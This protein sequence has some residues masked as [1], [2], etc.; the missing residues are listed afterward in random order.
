MNDRARPSRRR[1]CGRRLAL[2]MLL[3]AAGA[4]AA[5]G[6]P[7][8]LQFLH[9][10]ATTPDPET[11]AGVRLSLL[12]GRSGSVRAL[13]LGLVAGATS[14]DVRG[15]Q[16]QTFYAGVGGELR[17]LGLSA[18]VHL[19]QQ[20]V[21]GLQL[22]GLAAWSG[23]RVGGVQ[24][25][26]AVAYADGGFGGVQLSGLMNASDGPGG[27]LQ[28]ASVAN[29]NV[30]DFRGVQIAGFVNHA[31]AELSGLQLGGF[32]NAESAMGVQVGLVNLGGEMNGFQ[33][34]AINRA[35][36]LDG[37]PVG[38]INTTPGSPRGWIFYGSTLS[39]GNLSYHT[40]VNRWTSQLSLGYGDNHGSQDEA[41]TL[42]WHYGYRV[43]GDARWWLG[44][45]LGFVHIMP[46]ASD[47]PEV[48]D[49]LHWALQPR[50][51]G[52]LALGRH[53]G[54]WAAAGASFIQSSYDSGA[55]SETELLL[56][57]GVVLR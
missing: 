48:N 14:G 9:P 3:L 30:G 55:E 4:V 51:N 56:A 50:L 42:A 2:T 35:R 17:G 31:N 13:D 33:I 10:I 36:Q 39:L 24:A 19:V 49:R 25:A 20:D 54:I 46:K 41:L 26:G 5:A 45:D 27:F 23:G 47:D 34:G 32:N 37:V 52:E 15:L 16:W 40:E 1:V 12:W 11:D 57:G 29:V 8:S 18:G 43:L 7:I 53:V 28:L 21:S 6:T 22:G 44:I 38:L